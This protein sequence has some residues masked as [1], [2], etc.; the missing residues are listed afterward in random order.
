MVWGN[1]LS[2]VKE[3]ML[4]GLELFF[5]QWSNWKVGRTFLPVVISSYLFI[6]SL[7][8]YYRQFNFLINKLG[9]FP[10][11]RVPEEL[12]ETISDSLMFKSHKS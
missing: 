4:R 3:V 9:W 6:L 1:S 10:P 2:K 12:A 5:C 7:R 11:S 8:N